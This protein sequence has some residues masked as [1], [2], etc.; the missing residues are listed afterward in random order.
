MV[1]ALLSDITY[2]AKSLKFVIPILPANRGLGVVFNP[3]TQTIPPQKSS[4]PTNLYP[5]GLPTKESRL[6]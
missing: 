1:V 5:D 2:T 4:T 3:S 6:P